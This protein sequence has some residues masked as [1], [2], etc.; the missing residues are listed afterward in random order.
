MQEGR[1]GEGKGSMEDGS[2]VSCAVPGS[3]EDGSAVSCA[4]PCYAI[5]LYISY[6]LPKYHVVPCSAMPCRAT[7]YHIL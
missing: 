6:M 4:V 3:M 5:M 2:A 1:Q 7:L